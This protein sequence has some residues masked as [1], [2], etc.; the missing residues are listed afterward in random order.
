MKE[1]SRELTPHGCYILKE[2]IFQLIKEL[3]GKIDDEKNRNPTY[4]LLHK[5]CEQ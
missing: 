4:V 2:S 5:R 1:I 3:G